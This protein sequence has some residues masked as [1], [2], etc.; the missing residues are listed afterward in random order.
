MANSR[1]QSFLRNHRFPIA[2]FLIWRALIFLYQ[3][4]LQPSI[5][6]SHFSDTLSERLFTS[7]SNYWDAGHYLNIA[8]NGYVYPLENFFPAWPFL[9][10]LGSFITGNTELSSYILTFILGLATCILFYDIAKRLLS[11]PQAKAALLLFITFPAAIFL[12][13]GYTES[14]FLVLSLLSFY[15]IEKK[16]YLAAALTG[17]LTS[18]TRLVG[19]IMPAIFAVLPIPLLRRI[20][21]VLISFI[22]LLM[23]CTFLL[24][25]YN[26]PLYFSVAQKHWCE[27]NNN[28]TL[29]FP[30][31]T[32]Y[33]KF[34][35]LPS[36]N[37]LSTDGV[38]ED[39][40]N[41]AFSVIF[42]IFAATMIKTFP[43]QYWIYSFGIILVPLATGSTTSMARYVYLAFPIFFAMSRFIPSKYIIG[44]ILFIFA[45]IQLTFINKFTN[46]VWVG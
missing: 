17:G 16:Q 10:H 11:L 38:N 7:W 41:W 45:A 21:L 12:H 32:L 35:I 6:T 20:P 3:I 46:F 36:I 22:G 2:V 43:R 15:F 26:N 19:I 18:A 14:V 30:L 27:I 33:E 34:T 28:C 23:Y 37:T 44:I 13:A 24:I 1:I 25:N 5:A 42:L 8:T 29:T 39:T 31:Q 4:I 9:I 40:Y